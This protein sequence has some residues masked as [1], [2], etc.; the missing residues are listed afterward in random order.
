[1][2]ELFE[3]MYTMRQVA[4][5]TSASLKDVDNYMLHKHVTPYRETGKP[6]FSAFQMI[7]VDLC[8]RHLKLVRDVVEQLRP[9][10]SSTAVALDPFISDE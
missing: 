7:E 10:R 2:I 3:P 4:D 5:C 6:R 1:M 9:K 8:E